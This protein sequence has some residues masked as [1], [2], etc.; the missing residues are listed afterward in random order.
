MLCLFVSTSLQVENGSGN[1]QDVSIPV[2]LRIP[3]VEPGHSQNHL[4]T[5]K[6]QD[7]KINGLLSVRKDDFSVSL[8]PDGTHCVGCSVHVVC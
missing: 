4:T 6:I 7:H 1:G 8:P 3:F 5:F 2:H